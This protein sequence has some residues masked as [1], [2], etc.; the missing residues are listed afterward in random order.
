MFGGANQAD[1]ET[2]NVDI[3]GGNIEKAFGGSNQSGTVTTSNVT[4]ESSGTKQSLGGI[5][6]DVTYTAVEA[7]EW[8]KNQNPGYETYVTVEIKYTN[9]TD[10]TIN[11]W[12]SYIYAPDS[13][14]L[15]NYSS[16]SKITEDSGKYT[17]N[18]DSRWTTG[19][20]HSLPAN[21]TYEI[22]D[23]HLMSKVKADEFSLTY[24]FEGQGND[25]NSY[26]D[27][28]TGFMIFGGNNKGGE[29]TTSNV[30]IKSGYCYAVYGGN[31]EGGTNP[32]SNVTVDGGEPQEVYGGNNLGGENTNSKV[33]INSGKI[34][35]VYG[36]GNKAVTNVPYVRIQ[37]DAQ[38]SHSV[39]GGGNQAGINTDTKV[40]IFG[41]TIEGNAY[42]GGN[43]GT[44]TGNTYVHVKNA[45][46]NSS[47]YAGGN[48][49]TA[50]VYENA[51]VTVEGS[52]IN[53]AGSVF[54]GGNQAATG[55][56]GTN[57]SLSTVNITGGNI[58]KNVY[59]GAKTSG[60]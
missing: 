21:G 2:S 59:G 54:G 12:E 7:E 26:Q 6:M 31:N 60:V 48:G 11:K 20:I 57:N 32:T 58:G 56:S 40:E 23:V 33:I 18:Q 44:V 1:A 13:K 51:N 28:N 38:I 47:L 24:N 27:T 5:K 15:D 16:D 3:K 35:N 39:Y 30:N 55:T 22:R 29:T 46:L 17:I 43:E 4:L 49:T 14:L 53:I 9:S 42:G 10:T 19:N 52:N 34:Q 36:G 50:I 25:G 45:T 41:G 8:R 37:G